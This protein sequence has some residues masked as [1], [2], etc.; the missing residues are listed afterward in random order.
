MSAQDWMGNSRMVTLNWKMTLTCFHHYRLNQAG[1]RSLWTGTPTSHMLRCFKKHGRDSLQW[2]LPIHAYCSV[3]LLET[4]IYVHR[5][6]FLSL[7]HQYEKV[8]NL[9]KRWGIWSLWFN[10]KCSLLEELMDGRP[11]IS[12]KRRIIL[13]PLVPSTQALDGK[14]TSLIKLDI[15]RKDEEEGTCTFLIWSV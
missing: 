9:E 10:F 11:A 13:G 15:G 5:L 6:I 3:S 1:P 8:Y 4:Y 14:P 12:M 2:F 7:K